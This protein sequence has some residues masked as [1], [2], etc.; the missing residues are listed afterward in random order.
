MSLVERVHDHCFAVTYHGILA[1]SRPHF[2][3]DLLCSTQGQSQ[4]VTLLLNFISDGTFVTNPLA[5]A[6]MRRHMRANLDKRE[7][8]SMDVI[9]RE[10]AKLRKQKVDEEQKEEKEKQHLKSKPT[11]RVVSATSNSKPAASSA[12]THAAPTRTESAEVA[13]AA[14]NVAQAEQRLLRRLWPRRPT[15]PSGSPSPARSP[16]P[17]RCWQPRAT[18]WPKPRP[19]STSNLGMFP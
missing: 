7:L 3:L 13:K 17:R 14:Q 16:P 15:R 9:R 4:A 5:I 19:P 12:R 11:V 1:T 8:C 6:A 18:S 10:L 2:K